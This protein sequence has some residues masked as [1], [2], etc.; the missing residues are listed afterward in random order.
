MVL[1]AR[2]EDSG[3]DHSSSGQRLR[4][5]LDKPTFGSSGLGRTAESLKG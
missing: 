4:S 5:G 1:V 3:D 2:S